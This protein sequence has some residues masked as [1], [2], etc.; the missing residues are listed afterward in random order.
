MLILF[1]TKKYVRNNN[2]LFKVKWPK[3]VS[4]RLILISREAQLYSDTLCLT[5]YQNLKAFD[6]IPLRSKMKKVGS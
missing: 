1:Y 5:I 4:N 2:A 3:N 6:Y